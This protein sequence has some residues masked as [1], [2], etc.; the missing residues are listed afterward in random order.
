V[1]PR[2]ARVLVAGMPGAG[3]TTLAARLVDALVRERLAELLPLSDEL[4]LRGLRR[5]DPEARRGSRTTRQI[6]DA[7]LRDRRLDAGAPDD[8]SLVVALGPGRGVLEVVDVA[9]ARFA[10]DALHGDRLHPLRDL[11]A[12]AAAAILVLDAARWDVPEG[13]VRE[14]EFDRTVAFLDLLADAGPRLCAQLALIGWGRPMPR[15]RPHHEAL[16]RLDRTYDGPRAPRLSTWDYPG[17]AAA[18]DGDCARRFHA[19]VAPAAPALRLRERALRLGAASLG[20]LALV[21]LLLLGAGLG[22]NWRIAHTER[23]TTPSGE[24]LFIEEAEERLR[25]GRWAPLREAART[26]LEQHARFLEEDLAA[27]PAIAEPASGVNL[28]AAQYRAA[29]EDLAVAARILGPSADRLALA[30]RL[31]EK[32]RAA[33]MPPCEPAT[34]AAWEELWRTTEDAALREGAIAPRIRAVLALF[35][36]EAQRESDATEAYPDFLLPL[37]RV[38]AAHAPLAADEV[39]AAKARQWERAFAV[40]AARALALAQHAGGD[41]RAAPPGDPGAE[42]AE[43]VLDALERAPEPPPAG[44]LLRAG[45]L[46]GSALLAAAAPG[47]ATRERCARLLGPAGAQGLASMVPGAYHEMAVATREA[48]PARLAALARFLGLVPRAALAEPQRARIAALEAHLA[49]LAADRAYSLRVVRAYVGPEFDSLF[50]S[51]DMTV[52]AS[53][54]RA[55]ERVFGPLAKARERAFEAPLF[56]E[57]ELR[58]R[59]FERLEVRIA[60]DRRQV[61]LYRRDPG[62]CFGLRD[63]AGEWKD[64]AGHGGMTIAIAPEPPSPFDFAGWT[65]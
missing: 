65:E 41:P 63:L 16:D 48:G 44:F 18:L 8:E 45:R 17:P 54:E 19:L 57:G 49:D 58:W 3:K 43:A 31:R 1:K 32:A 56:G 21:A 40:L 13:R 30:A 39:R 60:D 37:L 51:F 24:R 26:G 14:A 33:E 61:G 34:I 20:G 42:E 4:A 28:Q 35:A 23:R 64:P 55:P 36:A 2:R 29:A 11:A 22:L 50:R 12:G 9:G 38:E 52:A 59:A 6:L 53:A 10:N 27:L 5:E 25:L 46:L 47:P 7:V 15:P 62:S